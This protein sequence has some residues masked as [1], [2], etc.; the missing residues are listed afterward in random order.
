M[1]LEKKLKQLRAN[2]N[3]DFDDHYVE[4]KNNLELRIKIS[5]CDWYEFGEKSSKFFLNLE[6][7]HTLQNQVQTLLY[8]QNEI[9]DK[10]QINDQLHHFCKVL[11]TENRQIENEN[12]TAYLN[13]ISI[14]VLTA[15]KMWR[16]NI[17][18]R[19]II[20]SKKFVK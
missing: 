2:A 5:K 12:I 8:G 10:N 9:A 17:K 1:I 4:C 15:T 11:F 3:F 20:S 19:V 14:P 7:Q 6:K 16:S 13:H 18:K